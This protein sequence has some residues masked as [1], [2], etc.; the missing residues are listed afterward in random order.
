MP[1]YA[2]C[3]CCGSGSAG[4]AGHCAEQ[5]TAQPSDHTDLPQHVGCDGE[6]GPDGRVD[7]EEQQPEQHASPDGQV[8][9]L[10]RS[11]ERRESTQS[12]SSGHFTPRRFLGSASAGLA[13]YC[14]WF[15][16]SSTG[17]LTSVNQ[18]SPPT[19]ASQRGRQSSPPICLS[20]SSKTS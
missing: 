8:A 5:L 14:A 18:S 17:C 11:R 4:D 10:S 3:G 12:T 19:F 7:T 6:R 16:A 1:P 2:W 9:E 20:R 13:V 15:Q